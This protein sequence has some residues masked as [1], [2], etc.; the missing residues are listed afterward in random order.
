MFPQLESQWLDK[1]QEHQ[2]LLDESI[3]YYSNAIK[4]MEDLGGGCGQWSHDVSLA[5]RLVCLCL[6]AYVH[7]Y[8]HMCGKSLNRGE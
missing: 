4:K 3:A 5:L 6:H 2:T 8:I 1:L 7:V